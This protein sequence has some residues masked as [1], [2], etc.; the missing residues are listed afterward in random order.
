M[1]D[2]QKTQR[3]DSLIFTH[4]TRHEAGLY[5]CSADNGSGKPA[6]AKVGTCVRNQGQKYEKEIYFHRKN[7][8]DVVDKTC[9]V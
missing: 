1:I 8:L 7:I 4:A 9:S 2:G 6:T 3:G 5:T